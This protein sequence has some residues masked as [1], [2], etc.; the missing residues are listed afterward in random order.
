MVLVDADILDI[1][2]R[3]EGAKAAKGALQRVSTVPFLPRICQEKSEKTIR[4]E[5]VTA[6]RR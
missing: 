6:P 1:T 4:K 5:S 2:T 3:C